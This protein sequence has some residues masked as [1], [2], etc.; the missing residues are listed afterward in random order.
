MAEPISFEY[1]RVDSNENNETGKPATDDVG[2]NEQ[3]ISTVAGPSQTTN[4]IKRICCPI[5][6]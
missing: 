6:L 3:K 2:A 4:I 5:K 1:L